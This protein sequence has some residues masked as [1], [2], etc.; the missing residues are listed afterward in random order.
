VKSLSSGIA[1]ARQPHVEAAA[2]TGVIALLVL[3]G[4][5]FNLDFLKRIAP[6]LVAMNPITAMAFLLA[7]ISVAL[8]SD[9][10]TANQSSARLWF[11]RACACCVG[12]LATAKLI[13]VFGGPDLGPDRWLLPSR[14]AVGFHMPNVMAPNT[15][16]NFLLVGI[17]LLCLHA[18]RRRLSSWACVF[19][20]ICGFQSLLAVLGYGYGITSF[21]RMTSFIPMA[22]QTAIAFLLVAFGIMS[23]Q[24]NRGFLAIISGNNVGGT[25]ARRLLPAAILVPAV[26]G[27]L[28][29]EGQRHGIFHHEFGTAL[30]T[31]TNMLVFA[32]LI[33]RN[34]YMLFRSDAQRTRAERRLRRAHSNLETRVHERT[35]ELSMANAELLTAQSELEARVRERTA[36]LAHSEERYRLLFESNPFAVW[37]YDIAT[38]SFLAVNEA[39]VRCYG[40]SR[41]EF[42]SMTIKDIRP[43][44]DIP[45]L[46]ANVA[47]PAGDFEPATNWQHRTKNGRIIDVE[48]TSRPLTFGGKAARLVLANDVT[49][50]K[51]G[52]D[53]L[54][55]MEKFLDSIV[56]NIPDMIFVKEAKELRFVRLNKAGQELLAL[57]KDQVLGKNAYDM[58]PREQADSFSEEDRLVLEKGLPIDIAEEEIATSK[59]RRLLHTKKI[60]ILNEKGEAVYLLGVSTDITERARSEKALKQA[61]E[62]ADRANRAKSEFLSRMSHELR[63]PM[64]AILGFA[65][66]LEMD[67][68]TAEQEEGVSHIIGGGRHLLDLINEVLDLSRI[69]AGRMSLSSEPVE[70]FEVLRET[71]ELVGQLA[72]E[73]EIRLIM[74]ESSDHYVVADRQRLK[75]VLINLVSNSIKY[76]RPGGSVTLTCDLEASRLRISV[77]DTGIGIPAERLAQIFTPFE[78]L[79]AERTDIE[80]TGLG[81][82]VTKGLIEAMEGVMGVQSVHGEG[83]TFWLE[84]PSTESP[85]RQA[86]AADEEIEIPSPDSGE[87]HRVLYIEDN[88]SN[89]RLIER[90]LLRRP[91]VELLS[92]RT[93]VDGLEMAGQHLPD[94]ILLDLNLP[95]IDGREV[96]QRLQTDPRCSAIPVV[97]LS[98][99][100]ISGQRDRLL[101]AGAAEYLTKPLN[102]KKFLHVLDQTL[103]GAV[104]LTANRNS[105]LSSESNQ[106]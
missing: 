82:A 90:V 43:P 27:W 30:Y 74:P 36:S 54:R 101:R 38:L 20:L 40:Y 67:E 21:Y 7:A 39:A 104:P 41:D 13:A 48:I 63:T 46:L 65:Q 52:E 96:L 58:F 95:D 29:L 17:A 28:Q 85:L 99:D 81:L 62:E 56:E 87:K 59:G 53:E 18:Q 103:D 32:G 44:R 34:A 91:A 76:N 106:E 12:F 50:R 61:K 102:V 94:L 89:L 100:A 70:V 22:L 3:F 16:F 69:E 77:I 33:A 92:A 1:R 26:L 45:V 6:G 31:V 23:C 68:L 97:V 9:G 35:A 88:R 73:R 2:A 5:I 98:A 79:G 15:A 93:G 83:T 71:I 86:Q 72:A 75:Q 64:N 78:R 57:A 55:R 51:R 105:S 37:V 11:A 8:F 14:L 10:K 42:L 60:P 49:A 4:W 66:L 24:A 84:L 19:A 47:Q 25:T 80:G